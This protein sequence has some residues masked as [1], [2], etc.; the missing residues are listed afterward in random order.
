MWPFVFDTTFTFLRR[1]RG[2]ENVFAAH[3][4]HLYQRLVIVGYSH[5]FVTLLYIGLSGAGAILALTWTLNLSGA[6]II[7]TLSLPLLC[8]V[9]WAFVVFQERICPT[10]LN[11]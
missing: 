9:L 7:V 11:S 6:T 10:P 2:G 1:L 3:R 8:L 5:R 4:S